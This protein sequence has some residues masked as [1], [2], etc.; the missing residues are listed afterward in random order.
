MFRHQARK[1]TLAFVGAAAATALAASSAAFAATPPPDRATTVQNDNEPNSP[2]DPPP[3]ADIQVQGISAFE[4][5]NLKVTYTFKVKN[6]GPDKMK[7]FANGKW[8]V[9]LTPA[10]HKCQDSGVADY[11]IT[12]NPGQSQ[13]VSFQCDPS[14]VQGAL[15]CETGSLYAMPAGKDPNPYNNK[16]TLS[17]YYVPV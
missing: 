8:C 12:L 17:H 2:P 9:K 13:S 5:N 11:Y 16:A 7:V 1:L 6:A 3:V 15:N 10:I 4:D 14:K